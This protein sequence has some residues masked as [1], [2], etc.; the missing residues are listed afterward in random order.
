MGAFGADRLTPGKAV[1]Q[2]PGADF[3]T[4]LPLPSTDSTLS[5]IPTMT[6]TPLPASR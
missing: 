3:A 4:S 6:Q 5:S 2:A 1:V